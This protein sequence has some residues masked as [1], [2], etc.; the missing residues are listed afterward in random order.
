MARAY[1][2]IAR[3]DLPSIG[4]DPLQVLDLKPNTSQGN[5]IYQGNGQTGY[6]SALPDRSA[7]V[8][9]ANGGG[10]RVTT[11]AYY[12]LTGYLLD[13]VN[14][15]PGGVNVTLADANA[16]T[17]ATN[18]CA[19]VAAGTALTS[20]AINAV[21]AAAC[22]GATGIGVGASTTTVEEIL[23]ILN[24]A[25]YRLPAGVVSGAG[26]VP[27]AHT[28]GA[29]VAARRGAFV[30]A[31]VVQVG[32]DVRG[33]N[34]YRTPI[35]VGTPV[36]TGLH[37]THFRAI[38]EIY[39]TG[40][41]SK[42]LLNGALSHLTP[43]TYEWNND[44]FTYGVAGTALTLSGTHIGVNHQARAVTVYAADGSII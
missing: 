5:S 2:C 25:V 39:N 40:D 44:T 10:I 20:A 18:L 6:Y 24:G 33:R 34:A 28:G 43:A 14:E 3:N 37:D 17:I 12:G 27:G 38:R 7:L 31:P 9:T 21:M 23:Q 19:A 22:G 4:G 26:A 16:T 32:T 11:V 8:S 29:F 41:L 15:V 30:I 35:T 13:T 1:I 42:S 36:Q